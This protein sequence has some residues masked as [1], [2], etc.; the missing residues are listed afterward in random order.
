MLDRWLYQQDGRQ[1][2][3]LQQAW[4]QRALTIVVV[5]SFFADSSCSLNVL[6]VNDLGSGQCLWRGLHA[7]VARFGEGRRVGRRSLRT[8]LVGRV[9]LFV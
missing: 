7:N 1:V 2:D 5:F 3:G 4:R 9:F 6:R 8:C